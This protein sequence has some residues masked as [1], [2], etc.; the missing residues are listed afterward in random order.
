MPGLRD[1]QPEF[2][3]NFGLAEMEVSYYGVSGGTVEALRGKISAILQDRPNIIVMQVGGNDFTGGEEPDHTEVPHNLI[4]LAKDLRRGHASVVII[5]KLFYRCRSR[6]LSTDRQLE[7][8]NGKVKCTNEVLQSSAKQLQ[9]DRILVWNHKGR[10]LLRD[11]IIG[12]DGTH[13]NQLGMKK[14]Y[15]SIR[16]ALITAQHL[17]QPGRRLYIKLTRKKTTSNPETN[18]KST[19]HIKLL[20][21][22]GYNKKH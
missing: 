5:G 2:Q 9:E 18:V 20:Y 19:T 1:E 22:C 17:L 3:A 6:H 12:Q 7:R 15:K 11:Q 4:R 21:R 8:Y 16:G 14:L 13:L 10:E